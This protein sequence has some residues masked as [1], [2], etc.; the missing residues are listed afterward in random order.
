MLRHAMLRAGHVESGSSVRP[1]PGAPLRQASGTRLLRGEDRCSQLRPRPR[2]RRMPHRFGR[3]NGSLLNQLAPQRG[4][5]SPQ[6]QVRLAQPR[7]APPA[8][9]PVGSRQSIGRPLGAL[10]VLEHGAVGI[11]QGLPVPPAAVRPPK[12]EPET[13]RCWPSINSP[14][15]KSA[16]E[17]PTLV[18]T[19]RGCSTEGPA[20]LT[21]RSVDNTPSL[22]SRPIAIASWADKCQ[23]SFPSPTGSR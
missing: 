13:T 7:Q 16:S 14:A 12:I 5:V 1:A 23:T 22:N 15:V 8:A 6:V 11:Q 19:K 10:G 21:T 20:K 9:Q 3:R 17:A 2:P 4:R 18:T